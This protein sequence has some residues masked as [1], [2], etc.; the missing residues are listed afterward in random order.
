[1]FLP[2]SELSNP[3]YIK[4]YDIETVEVY[5]D[6]I[7]EDGSDNWNSLYKNKKTTFRTMRS[8]YSYTVEDM[9]EMWFMNNA[10]NYLLR[11]FY[12]GIKEYCK[13]QEM[14]KECYKVIKTL[15]EFEPIREEIDDIFNPNTPARSIRTLNGEFRVKVIDRMLEENMTI[16]KSEVMSKLL[17]K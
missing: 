2:D 7:D 13:P 15:P 4:E 14:A 12:E 16:I 1:M 8:C 17:N 10:A 9:K 11:N 6:I 5:S 3:K